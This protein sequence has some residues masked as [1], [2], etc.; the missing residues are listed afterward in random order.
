MQEN[1]SGKARKVS[2]ARRNGEERDEHRMLFCKVH[3]E[4]TG[5]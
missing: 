3:G 5:R 4:K 1:R 2:D